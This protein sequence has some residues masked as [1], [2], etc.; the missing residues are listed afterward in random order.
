MNGKL[1]LMCISVSEHQE[2]PEEDVKEKNYDG[3]N[4]E[5]LHT[6]IRCDFCA[7]FSCQTKTHSQP[8]K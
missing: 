1:V 6:E 5:M 7:R 3:N 4:S 8:N 2:A